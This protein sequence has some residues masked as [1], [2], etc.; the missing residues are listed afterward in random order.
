MTNQYKKPE[1]LE[2]GKAQNEILSQKE[3]DTQTDNLNVPMRTDAP[4]LDDFDE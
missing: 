3:L 4:T 1:A 2:L